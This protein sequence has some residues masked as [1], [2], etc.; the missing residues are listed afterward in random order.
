M[1]V[2]VWNTPVLLP[3]SASELGF[4]VKAA[5]VLRSSSESAAESH[6]I[7][8]MAYDSD[9]SESRFKSGSVNV[10]TISCPRT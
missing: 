1:V 6:W 10:I 7:K 4:E 2:T 5:V 9:E 3:V 8:F